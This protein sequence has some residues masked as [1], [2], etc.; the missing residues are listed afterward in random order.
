MQSTCKYNF[1]KRFFSSLQTASLRQPTSY[2]IHRRPSYEQP[3]SDKPLQSRNLTTPVKRTTQLSTKSPTS[4][5][6]PSTSA[7][8]KIP[9]YSSRSF[10]DQ[11]KSKDLGTK[12]KDTLKIGDMS[13]PVLSGTVN[14]FSSNWTLKSPDTNPQFNSDKTLESVVRSRTGS[15]SSFGKKPKESDTAKSTLFGSSSSNSS[16]SPPNISTKKYSSST[17]DLYNSSSMFQRKSSLTIEE[18]SPSVKTSVSSTS[19]NTA[20]KLPRYQPYMGWQRRTSLTN[21]SEQVS[22]VSKDSYKNPPKTSLFNR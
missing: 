4:P 15:F 16:L 22:A 2:T 6:K 10:G 5:S 1:N 7:F 8:K 13:P 20:S 11:S 14:P 17:S 3:I 18:P 21:E 12:E 9:S 19:L